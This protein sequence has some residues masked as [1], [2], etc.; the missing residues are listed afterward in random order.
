V[1][2]WTLGTGEGPTT[3]AVLWEKQFVGRMVRWQVSVPHDIDK[4]SPPISN[5]I[6]IKYL[7]SPAAKEA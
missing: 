4:I 1:D 7:F 5:Q 6:K 2:R 3:E